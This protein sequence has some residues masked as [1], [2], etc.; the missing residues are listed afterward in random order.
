MAHL[1]AVDT[2]IQVASANQERFS[3]SSAPTPATGAEYFQEGVVL[4]TVGGDLFPPC[5]EPAHRAHGLR[6]CKQL[7]V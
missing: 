1:C 5:P 4:P 2:F 7:V 3:L 6:N